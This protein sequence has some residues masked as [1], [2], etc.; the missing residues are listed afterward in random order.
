MMKRRETECMLMRRYHV[1]EDEDDG[2]GELHPTSSFFLS[3]EQHPRLRRASAIDEDLTTR[4]RM[5]HRPPAP[6]IN[7]AR[8]IEQ[9]LA[10]P[11]ATRDSNESDPSESGKTVPAPA[12][13][14]MC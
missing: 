10:R 9:T 11:A 14:T 4:R 8:E 7:V 13:E 6:T 2:S 12:S 1:S 5:H 3:H